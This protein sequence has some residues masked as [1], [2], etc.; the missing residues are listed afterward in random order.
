MDRSSKDAAESDEAR[1][2]AAL[3]TIERMLIA[4]APG[5]KDRAAVSAIEAQLRT[6]EQA[7]GTRNGSGLVREKTASIRAGLEILYSE[8]KHEKYGGAERYRGHVMNDCASL[9]IVLSNI[10]RATDGTA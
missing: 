5:R 9:R 6:L 7:V 8:R 1:A 3:T 4:Y 10:F 2:K